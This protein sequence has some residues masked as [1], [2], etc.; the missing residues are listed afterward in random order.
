MCRIFLQNI[1]FPFHPGLCYVLFVESFVIHL[2]TF[3]Q[4]HQG[5]VN[6]LAWNSSG[7]LL[8]SGSDDAR[9][10]FSL[11]YS[12]TSIDL[13]SQTHYSVTNGGCVDKRIHSRTDSTFREEAYYYSPCSCVSCYS[14][15]VCKAAGYEKSNLQS[16]S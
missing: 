8:I 12:G 5:C 9:V 10:P 15:V 1:L 3:L 7:S 16:F 14:Q 13:H 2:T 4:G 11:F 6:A